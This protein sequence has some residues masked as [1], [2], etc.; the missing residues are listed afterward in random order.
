MGNKWL[1]VKLVRHPL[2]RDG[3][4]QWVMG[5][6]GHSWRP[7]K[8]FD[9]RPSNRDVYAFLEDHWEFSPSG[10]MLRGSE[11]KNGEFVP[12]QWRDFRLLAAGVRT[13]TW[14]HAIGE[15]PVRFHRGE[16]RK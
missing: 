5:H 4:Q 7:V 13:R 14:R 15:E 12:V 10:R 1:L 11:L 16:R 8:A 2:D 9:A 6:E 3:G